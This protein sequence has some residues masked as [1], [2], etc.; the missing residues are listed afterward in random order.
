M[1]NNSLDNQQSHM[2]QI[3]KAAVPYLDHKSKKSVG[4]IIK[5]NE[6][7]DSLHKLNT[8]EEL[9]TCELGE[10]K[11]DIEGMLESIRP[12]CNEKETELVDLVLNFI[13]ARNLYTTYQTLAAANTE[14]SKEQTD[15]SSS[16]FGINNMQDFI[17]SMLTPEQQSNFQNMSAVMSAMDWNKA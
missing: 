7:A 5:T 12:H 10:D 1:E 9:S 4:I 11:T 15:N 3:L 13:K 8:R 2:F 16:F 6:L 17:M 14:K